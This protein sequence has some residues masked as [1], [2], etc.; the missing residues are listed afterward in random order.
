MCSFFQQSLIISEIIEAFSF[1]RGFRTFLM[2]WIQFGSRVRRCGS[3]RNRTQLLDVKN[4]MVASNTA[5]LFQ[6]PI[7][8]P[9]LA[10]AN[11]PANWCNERAVTGLS[12][13]PLKK[14][15]IA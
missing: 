15:Q 5:M 10:M 4:F 13:H 1:R 7:N 2:L 14:R 9:R 12:N 8:S 6:G 3:G 11:V